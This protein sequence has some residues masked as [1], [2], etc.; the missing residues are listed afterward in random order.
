[1]AIP[2]AVDPM[3]ASRLAKK[4]Q[5]KPFVQRTFDET[6]HTASSSISEEEGLYCLL[7]RVAVGG[8]VKFNLAT[9]INN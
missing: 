5:A 3:Y 6:H 4:I 9:N 8:A 7:E 2:E 1:V